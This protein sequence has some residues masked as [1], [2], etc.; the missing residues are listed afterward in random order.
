MMK[1]LFAV[2]LMAGFLMS[3]VAVT[4]AIA[5]ERHPHIRKAIVELK[6]AKVELQTAAHDFGGHRVEALASLDKALEQLNLCLQ[7]DKK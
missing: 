4:P 5:K 3:M 7:N 2:G 6:A 1:K